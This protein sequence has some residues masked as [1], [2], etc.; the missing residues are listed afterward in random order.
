MNAPFAEKEGKAAVA[1][2][3]A[4]LGDRSRWYAFFGSILGGILVGLLVWLLRGR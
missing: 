3:R 4:A 1:R 2:V